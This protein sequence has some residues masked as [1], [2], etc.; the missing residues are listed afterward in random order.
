MPKT[1]LQLGK[2][3]D[4][5]GVLPILLFEFNRTGQKPALISAQEFAPLVSDIPYL[6][7]VIF[8]GHWSDLA[9]AVKFARA[10]FPSVVVL[11]TFG[12][13]F[14]IQKRRSSFQLDQWDRAGCLHLWDTLP[15]VLPRPAN[16]GALAKQHLGEK[17]AI[18][19]GDYSQSSPFRFMDELVSLIRETFGTTHRILRLSEI[20]LPHPLDL[21][22]LYDA[23][24]LIV[25]IDTIHLH[26][27]KASTTPA[28]ALLS[29]VPTRW[30][31]SAPSNHFRFYCTYG[32]FPNRKGQ[33]LQSAQ[34]ALNGSP[35]TDFNTSV[36]EDVSAVVPIYRPEAAILNRCLTALIPQVGEIVVCRDQTGILPQQAL[37]HPKVNY[38]CSS[39]SNTGFGRN[40]NFG[41]KHTNG[42]WIL[43]CNDDVELGV[44][45]VQKMLKVAAPN[46]GIVGCQ[47]RFQDGRIQTGG[48]LRKPNARGWENID[49][50]KREPTFKEPLELEDVRGAVMLTRRQA[51][52]KAGQWDRD[53][54]LYCEDNSLCLAIRRAG[55][56]VMYTPL[57]RG[58]H[59]EGR[60]TKTLGHPLM[61]F[62]RQSTAIFERKWGAYLDH[63]A[64]RIPGNFDC[65]NGELPTVLAPS[66]VVVYVHVPHD[67]EHIELT[68]RFVFSCL[69]NPGGVGHRIIVV[70]QGRPPT[71]EMR[72][73][74]LTLPNVSFYQH[75]DSGWDI[76][77]FIAVSKTI[78][79]DM[80]VCLGGTAFVQRQGWLQRMVSVWQKHGPGLYG[81]Q[82]TYEV[83]PHLNTSGFWCSPSL[84]ANYPIKVNTKLQRYD[85]EHG[86]NALWKLAYKKGCKVMLATWDGE[87]EWPEWRKPPN[88]Y[89]R[90]DQSNCVTFFRHSSNYAAADASLK[91][92]ME[93]LA[94]TITDPNYIRLKREY[95]EACPKKI[96]VLAEKAGLTGLSD[97][98]K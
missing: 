31:G 6:T 42:R 86:R 46:V 13:D 30:H 59:D 10:R 24:K 53:F 67:Q 12:R 74:L 64:T 85:F 27:C 58:L 18:L 50:G 75:D 8:D 38:V 78:P 26:L 41:A 96:P 54:F 63:N 84:L 37:K 33:L 17:P 69:K 25:T 19:I 15:L 40:C 66:V 82:A 4:I 1:Y 28:I 60:S 51:F 32:E 47:L 97:G 14:P 95:D 83:S 9:G 29:D 80:M 7:P 20:R 71:Q 45:A 77:A 88:I 93:K 11:S 2:H 91:R 70:C 76:G 5:L 52:Y 43:F 44:D 48:C 21:L 72:K 68:R 65:F 87:Y 92:A 39:E 55:Y 89:R 23:A 3:G 62:V 79:E 57:A 16:A 73:L 81:S 56:R 94:D 98:V 36:A 49:W 34:E 61:D 22:A 90:G 35:P